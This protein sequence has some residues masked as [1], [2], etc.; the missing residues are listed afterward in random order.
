M[1]DALEAHDFVASRFDVELLNEPWIRSTR[2]TVAP[3]ERL[4]YYPF[5]EHAGGSGMGVKRDIFLAVGGFDDSLPVVQ[6]ADLCIRLQLAGTELVHIADAVVHVRYRTG[7]RDIYRQGRAYAWDNARLQA[8]YANGHRAE[9]TWKWPLRHW[10]TIGAAAV[11]VH[12]RAARAQL[13]WV[14]G[15]QVGRIRGSLRYRV[16]AT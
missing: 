2:R 10:K 5:L 7:F 1:S 9:D 4:P 12:D 15:W 13:A 14:A 3:G 8:R 16:P 11:R 6:D